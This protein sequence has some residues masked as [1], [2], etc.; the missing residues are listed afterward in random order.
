MILAQLAAGQDGYLDR[1]ME[2]LET[3]ARESLPIFIL[4]LGLLV[5]AIVVFI[6]IRRARPH[7]RRRSE[8][9][10]LLR[11]LAEANE[12]DERQQ[13]LIRRLAQLLGLK[14]PGTAFVRP[15]LLS[16]YARSAGQNLTAA[17]NSALQSAVSA[18][19]AKLFGEAE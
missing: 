4:L 3:H 2:G 8:M 5:G 9:N 7:F 15:S 11:A 16:Q 6:V 13:G 10:A 17:E 1:F 18:L 19:R 12:L 14:N